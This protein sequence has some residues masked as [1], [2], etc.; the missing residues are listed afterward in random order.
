MIIMIKLYST[1]NC[2]VCSMVKKALDDSKFRY[3][4]KSAVDDY[5]ELEQDCLLMNIDI[6]ELKSSPA[7]V[8]GDLIYEGEDCVEALNEGE[9]EEF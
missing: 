8:A 9:L 1:T 6:K 2:K 4:L 3:E 7:L 5:D